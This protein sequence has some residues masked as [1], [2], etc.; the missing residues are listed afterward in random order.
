[1]YR[2]VIEQQSVP[3]MYSFNYP[4]CLNVKYCNYN[5]KKF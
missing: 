4:V 1:M 2:K 5:Q 3:C